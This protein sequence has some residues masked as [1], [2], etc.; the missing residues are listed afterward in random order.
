MCSMI[1][2]TYG[3]MY[4][5]GP[6]S[7]KGGEPMKYLI[8]RPVWFG[9]GPRRSSG[10]ARSMDDGTAGWQWAGIAFVADGIAR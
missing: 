8:Y 10:P 3:A 9:F 7:C 5:S 6:H 1:S 2:S 4:R